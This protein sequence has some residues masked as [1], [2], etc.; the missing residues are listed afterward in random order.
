MVVAF[1]KIGVS[2]ELLVKRLGHKLDT[3]TPD[4]LADL[5]GIFTS[6]KDGVTKIADWFGDKP[7]DVDPDGDDAGDSAP[8]SGIAAVVKKQA[9]VAAKEKIVEKATEDRKSTRLNS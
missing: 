4:E 8:K 1:A 7:A 2:D 3:T 6:L 9:A 5:H